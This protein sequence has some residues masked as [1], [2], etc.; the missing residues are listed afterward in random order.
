MTYEN[1]IGE[2]AVK[3]NTHGGTRTHNLLLRRQTPYPLGHAGTTLTLPDRR[4]NH[5]H[6][7]RRPGLVAAVATFIDDGDGLHA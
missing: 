4:P 6:S 7:S 5:S 1:C 3:E 2:M